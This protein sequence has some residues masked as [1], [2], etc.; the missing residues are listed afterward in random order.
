M[1]TKVHAI[2]FKADSKLLSFVE[3]RVNKLELYNDKMILSEVFLKLD[4]SAILS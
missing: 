4:K 2:D 3:K 1:Q